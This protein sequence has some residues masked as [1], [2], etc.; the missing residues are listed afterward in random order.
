LPD[1]RPPNPMGG[2]GAALCLKTHSWALLRCRPASA[3]NARH[4]P[5]GHFSPAARRCKFAVH[6]RLAAVAALYP[7]EAPPTASKTRTVLANLQLFASGC[8]QIV[9]TKS[10]C[11]EEEGQVV[12]RTDPRG[13]GSGRN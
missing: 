10:D 8:N 13:P 9:E 12:I 4:G 2:T 5:S 3:P 6:S 11:R 7:T 1:R